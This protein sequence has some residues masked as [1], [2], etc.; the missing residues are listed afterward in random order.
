M[1]IV[2]NTASSYLFSYLFFQVFVGIPVEGQRLSILRSL[3]HDIPL[4]PSVSLQNIAE[5]TPG[6]VGADLASI[7]HHAHFVA[8]CEAKVLQLTSYF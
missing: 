1:E 8:V 2:V 3:L 4:K 6:Y 5:S 7:V